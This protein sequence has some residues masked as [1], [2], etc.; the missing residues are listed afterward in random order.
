[1]RLWP[2]G[3][4]LVLTFAGALLV[5]TAVFYTGWDLLGA[6]GLKPEHRLDSKTLFDLVKLSFGVVAGAGALVALVV[7]YRRQRVD[8]DGA[9]REAT[10]L[11]T[12]RFTTAVSQLGADSAA[13][14]LGGVHALAGLADDAPTRDLRQ[15]CIDVL[16]A[17]LRLPYTAQ[18]DLPAGDP[19]SQ[20]AY[21]A[22]REVRHT[23][24]RVIRDHFRLASDHPHCWQGHHLDF[25]NVIFDGGDLTGAVFLNSV[26][27]FSGAVFNGG[28]MR[29]NEAVFSGKVD[30]F[31]AAFD[32]GAV[33]FGDSLFLGGEVSFSQAKFRGS[34]IDFRN[35]LFS[36]SA[37]DFTRAAFDEGEVY[38]N[39]AQF[40]SG[41]V[42]FKAARFT[43][44]EVDLSGAAFSGSRVDFSF[45]HFATGT[46]AFVGNQF[47]GGT[48][49]FN[50]ARFRGATVDYSSAVFSGSTVSFESG[51]F[52][53]G[54][55]DF[56]GVR[57]DSG[58]VDFSMARFSGAA[59]DFASAQFS[60]AAVSF[61]T[62]SGEA[63]P[64]LVPAS[65]APLPA[66]LTLPPH[67]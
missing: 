67:W 3:T 27:D 51:R 16:C 7:A 9:L 46:V 54:V 26:V 13:V 53:D 23:V 18:D 49:A 36:G 14:R 44:S 4:V 55:V 47:S 30:F 39:D 41:V 62:V 45:C 29:F 6:R 37:V 17:Y 33:D 40:D 8:E 58:S 15:T 43:G 20:H 66:D 24:I 25:T 28:T 2:V 48:V 59:I 42:N 34:M 61:G 50:R 31:R 64:G 10:R 52:S 1:M 32:A 65:G 38:F 56:A 22:L 63:P 57:F 21:L 5:A 11:H 60:G 19:E 12:E 35:A